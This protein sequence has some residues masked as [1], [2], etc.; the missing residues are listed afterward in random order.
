MWGA[1]EEFRMVS[2]PLKPL[3]CK[4]PWNIGQVALPEACARVGARCKAR[5]VPAKLAT[6]TRSVYRISIFCFIIFSQEQHMSKTIGSPS[7]L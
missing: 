6:N 2:Y 4:L 7:R 5:N 1:L 3:C